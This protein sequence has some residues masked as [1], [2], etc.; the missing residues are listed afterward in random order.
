MIGLNCLS[1]NI[2]GFR[3]NHFTLKHLC[4]KLQPDFIFLSEPQVFKCDLSLYSKP[5]SHQYS[6]LLN[7]EENNNPE[8]AL[9]KS[10]AHGG[11]LLMWKS[12]YDPFITPIPTPSPAFLPILLNMPGYCPSIHI[13]LYLPTSGRDPEFVDALALLDIFLEEMTLIHNC[14][15]YIRGDA[16]CNPKNLPR[17]S[18]FQHFC[19]KH[20]L[21]SIDF[22][23]P[24]H[25]HFTGQGLYDAQLDVLLHQVKAPQETLS[26]IICKLQHPLI[27][28]AH[29]V[30]LSVCPL[31]AQTNFPLDSSENIK[32]VKVR[33]TRIKILWNENSQEYQSLVSD[34]LTRLRK[35]WNDS[36]SP[37]S[38]SILLASTNDALTTCAAATNRSIKLGLA[39]KPKIQALDPSVRAAQARSLRLS[40]LLRSL[41]SSRAPEAQIDEA[42]RALAAARSLCRKVINYS[43]KSACDERD[44]LTFSILSSNPA[45]LYKSIKNSKNSSSSKIHSL[46]VGAKVYSGS[47]VSDGFYDSLSSLKCPDMSNIYT[48]SSYQSIANDYATIRKICS[49]GLKIPAVSTKVATDI[50]YS[51]RPDVNDLYSI[52]ARHYIN[53]G[54]EGVRHFY[55]LMNLIISDINLFSLPELNSVW[56]MVLHKGHGK[57]KDLD[58]S[59]RTISTCPLLSKA[60]DKYIGSLYESGWAAAQ[61]ETQFQG[62][63]SSH[64]LAALLLTETIQFSLHSTKKPLFVLL[65]DAKS[66][67]DKILVEC[68][69]RNAFIAGSRDQGLLYLAD[70]LSNRLTYVEWDKCLMGPIHD[71]LGVEQGGCNSDRLY[72]LANNEQLSTAQESKLGLNMNGICVSSV[73][74]ADD[75]CLVSDCIF[76]LQL[77]LQLTEEYCAKYH[78]ELVPEK[79]KLLCFSPPGL[80]SSVAYWKSVSPVSL[81][82]KKIAFNAEAEHVGIVRSVHG[83]LP[84]I[85]S[86]ISAHNRALQSV[87]GSGIAR[88]HHGNPAASLRIEVLYALPKLLSGLAALV[89]SKS[90]RDIVHHHYKKSLE[91]LQRLHRATPE[92]VVCFLG[93]SLPLTAHLDLRQLSLFGMISR[94]G[95]GCI[96]HHHACYTLANAKQSEKS[97]FIQIRDICD[98]YSL[99]SPDVIHQPT[100]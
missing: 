33:N 60:I 4:D 43:T 71:K 81:G 85:L 56:A 97:W 1:W 62:P 95:P 90:E 83:N 59:Y 77:L 79:T 91:R 64:D 39:T 5:F 51:L 49:S 34:T 40:R 54:L 36:G 45:K 2:E 12:I 96:L 42:K 30:V 55:F 88:S 8:L 93:G 21:N 57:P 84:S 48:S 69:I 50:L 58:R 17:S 7:S 6:F 18:L 53:A 14:P 70:R 28:S 32:A 76:K 94:L 3:R 68:I 86:R 52:T 13:A 15:I 63:G 37:V 66:A 89:L 75:T 19:L 16:N 92:P 41:V 99:P 9:D 98:K 67:F 24:T 73:G 78:V 100:K 74:Q 61:A 10:K 25:H 23:H 87:L 35:T 26:S 46:K 29:D 22:N 65:L 20:S 31:K 44:A 80:E 11:T 27:D 82:S 72:K 47:S 38:V